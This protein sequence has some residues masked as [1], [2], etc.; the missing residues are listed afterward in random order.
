MK[1]DVRHLMS[2]DKGELRGIKHSMQQG[3]C[4]DYLTLSTD[5]RICKWTRFNDEQGGEGDASLG[6]LSVNLLEE[7]WRRKMNMAG[8]KQIRWALCEVEWVER[9]APLSNGCGSPY[10][11]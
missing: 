4:N 1:S 10:L 2:K 3:S 9:R 8:F 11:C 5:E 7:L 6:E